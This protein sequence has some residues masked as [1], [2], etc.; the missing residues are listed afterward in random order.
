MA[1]NLPLNSCQWSYQ[2][3]WNNEIRISLRNR[4]HALLDMYNIPLQKIDN[5]SH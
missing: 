3:K 2:N 1:Y 5:W 4:S